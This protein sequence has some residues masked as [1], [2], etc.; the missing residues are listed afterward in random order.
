MASFVFTQAK[1]DILNGTI[2]LSSDDFYAVLVGGST[3]YTPSEA[4]TQRSSL[5]LTAGT[6]SEAKD[7]INRQLDLNGSTVE[8]TFTNPIWNALSA[9]NNPIT[10]IVICKK[11]GGTFAATDPVVAF[12]EFSA[13][14]TSTGATFQVTATNNVYLSVT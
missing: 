4:I 13:E 11:A 6:N 9:T 8:L 14:Y 10:G 3:G 7:L 12:L 1:L 5:V 2:D